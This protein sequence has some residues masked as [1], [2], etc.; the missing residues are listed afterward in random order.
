LDSFCIRGIDDN[1][2]FLNALATHPKF[3]AGDMSTGFI[4]EHFPEGFNSAKVD[5]A[6]NNILPVVAG[7][8]QHVLDERRARASQLTRKY[9]ARSVNEEL[10]LSVTLADQA[11]AVTAAGR[12]YAVT[13]NW[14][15]HDY[16]F[17]ATINGEEF[18]VQ[19]ERNPLGWRLANGGRVA[20]IRVLTA[21]AAELLHLI[22]EKQPPDLS[23][24][25]LSPMP[26]L[27][28]R[29]QVSEGEEV[30]AGQEL[31]VVEAM[32]MENSL[33]AT[34]DAVVAVVRA[35]AGDLLVA[36][37]SILEFE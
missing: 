3:A 29:L 19:I 35:K 34:Q 23:R 15:L 20:D 33:R 8:L 4:E 2:S 12:D 25:L 5:L 17:H 6:D 37:Q 7:V 11:Y 1:I 27:L 22:P 16:V 30:K 24:F 32:K 14:Q 21:R 36:G 10:P 26:G 31:A 28:V 13:T 9:V 18:A